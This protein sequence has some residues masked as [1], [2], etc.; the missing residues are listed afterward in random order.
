MADT[1][2]ILSGGP[3][4]RP[5]YSSQTQPIL[6]PNSGSLGYQDNKTQRTSQGSSSNN[7]HSHG[8]CHNAICAWL[9]LLSSLLDQNQPPRHSTWETD[10]FP[11]EQIG[12]MLVTTF[13]LEHAGSLSHGKGAGARKTTAST[14]ADVILGTAP[15]MSRKRN[16]SANST[17]RVE[18]DDDHDPPEDDGGG[19]R[20]RSSKRARADE[21]L[22]PHHA[23]FAC[24]FFKMNP[25]RHQ[26]CLFYKMS[27]ISYVKQH[28]QRT[29]RGPR[30]RC[31]VCHDVFP[32]QAAYDRHLT[33]HECQGPRSKGRHDEMTEVQWEEIGRLTSRRAGS[34]TESMWY[35]MFEVLFPGAPRPETPYVGSGIAEMTT[36]FRDYV[37]ERGTGII[38][39]HLESTGCWQ[40][41]ESTGINPD[42]LLHFVMTSGIELI[43]E[44]WGRAEGSPGRELAPSSM[45]PARAS[46][47]RAVFRGEPDV[48]V[49]HH[50]A[51][52]P[53]AAAQTAGFLPPLA[54]LYAPRTP[55][56][57]VE[58]ITS[59][60]TY[61][62]RAHSSVSLADTAQLFD[63]PNDGTR[64]TVVRRRHGPPSSGSGSVDMA[65]DG[66]GSR[67]TPTRG[68][69]DLSISA[70]TE[71]TTTSSS[72]FDRA[73]SSRHEYDT[74]P[75]MR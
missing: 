52:T 15:Q 70:L 54:A 32:D 39:S 40:S 9:S 60:T 19:D 1:L 5:C 6:S 41:L 45:A 50:G 4:L 21:S 48:G 11:G 10:A 33:A 42:P 62:A 74:S 38:K 64:D 14:A 27:K 30:W 35:A 68:P 23:S 66:G 56:S 51:G 26:A 34:T 47:P 63:S 20:P 31:S 25:V 75:D 37:K 73:S 69:R 28:L 67:T 17:G 36:H 2:H 65:L 58:S 49:H 44:N 61:H 46:L 13:I 43:F 72:L 8:T 18:N 53:T 29:H 59:P 16:S 7:S 22:S 12:A 24:P 57:V 55:P 71:E 3:L